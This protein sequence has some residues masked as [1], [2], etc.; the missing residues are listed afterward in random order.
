[1]PAAQW[2]YENF[3]L[4]NVASPVST[5]GIICTTRPV[6]S[7]YSGAQFSVFFSGLYTVGAGATTCTF[8]IREQSL[9]GARLTPNVNMS[10]AANNVL[11]IALGVID[12][13]AG[14]VA[15]FTW[16][17]TVLQNG[18]TGAGG[19]TAGYSRVVTPV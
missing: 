11:W 3:V 12:A 2:S 19:L 10:Y 18:G 8:A 17:L 14:D 1:M 6:S 16:V 15:G 4:A 7:P 5:E 13:P 9:T